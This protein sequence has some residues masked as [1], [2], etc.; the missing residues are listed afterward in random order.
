MLSTKS[1]SL[2]TDNTAWYE[3]TCKQF[4]HSCTEDCAQLESS[5]SDD[6]SMS[7]VVQWLDDTSMKGQ[8]LVYVATVP[9]LSLLVRDRQSSMTSSERFSQ[10]VRASHFISFQKIHNIRGY[11]FYESVSVQ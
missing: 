3:S 11:T 9:V 8:E 4:S 5:A 6:S 2:I 1:H 10:Y 7:A